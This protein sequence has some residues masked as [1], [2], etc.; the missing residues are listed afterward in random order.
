MSDDITERVTVVCDAVVA[1]MGSSAGGKTKR[2]ALQA[3]ASSVW[4]LTGEVATAESVQAA[5]DRLVDDEAFAQRVYDV[6]M[7]RPDAEG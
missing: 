7:P 4:A 5:I 6:P 3:L 1:L 2:R